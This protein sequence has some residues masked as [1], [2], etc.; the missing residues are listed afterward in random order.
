MKLLLAYSYR[1]L[2]A[3]RLTTLLTA[4]GMA[5]V[6]FA[7]AAIVMLAEGLESTLVDSGSFQNAVVL[8]KSAN[9]EVQSGV[10]RQE[11]AIVET[12]P[13]IALGVQGRPLVAKEVVVLINLRKRGSGST[14]NVTIRGVSEASLA[15]RPQV[16]VAAGRLPRPGSA[17]IMV[18][19]GIAQRFQG[20]G[21]NDTL[22]FA[23]NDWKVVGIFDAGNTGFSSEIWGDADQFMQA[24][25]RQAYSSVI[26]RMHDPD[27]FKMVKERIEGDPR[28]TVDLKREV[29]YYREQSEM[30]ANFLRILGTA[31]TII[32]SVGAVVG[33]MI[34]MY[35][36]VANR[37]GEIG[38]LRAMGFQRSV[39]LSA[40]LVESLLLG[41]V[42]GLG[43]LFLA[44]FLQFFTVS[45]TNFQTFAELAFQFRLNVEIVAEGLGFA[46]VM[47]FAGGLLPAFRAA[48][49]NIVEALREA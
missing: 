23:K 19:E 46:L 8:R 30:T 48:R 31:L 34:T 32:F 44:S 7:F 2:L 10:S 21:L 26:F 24:F 4:G 1:N 18:G 5:L 15:L 27:T 42:G 13:E 49:M 35:A 45:T 43:G 6:V 40:F 28:L 36:A 17:E 38:T 3:R 14:S 25:R 16:R 29:D 47:G 33:A 9:S 37:T 39:I 22:S 11:A 12:Q 20:A 41:F